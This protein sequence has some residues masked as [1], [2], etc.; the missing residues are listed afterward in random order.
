[1]NKFFLSMIL[2]ALVFGGV[3]SWV[4]VS[5]AYTPAMMFGAVLFAAIVVMFA[6]TFAWLAVSEFFRT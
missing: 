5:I 4:L 1:M 3:F 6:A 2:L